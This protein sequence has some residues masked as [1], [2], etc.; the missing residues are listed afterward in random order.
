MDD[1][2]DEFHKKFVIKNAINNIINNNFPYIE[3]RMNIC[4][5]CEHF[6]NNI[7]KQCGCFMPAKTSIKTA[8]CPQKKW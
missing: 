2:S 3:T 6:W 4:K 1:K 5:S 8:K 7:C